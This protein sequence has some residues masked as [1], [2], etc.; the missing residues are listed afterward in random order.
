MSL[1]MA[2]KLAMGLREL[3]GVGFANLARLNN[4]GGWKQVLM[5]IFFLFPR[6][7]TF[8]AKESGDGQT[9]IER[10]IDRHIERRRDRETER[11]RGGEMVRW[12]DGETERW[13]NREAETGRYKETEKLRGIK[14]TRL[15]HT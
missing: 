1:L 7:G 10:H 2:N 5:V 3:C 8:F 11:W 12:R 6:S 9:Q 14:C 15:I 13:I 4:G